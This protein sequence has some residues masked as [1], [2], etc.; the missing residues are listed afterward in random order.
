MKKRRGADSHAKV[1][2]TFHSEKQ[3][4]RIFNGFDFDRSGSVSLTEFHHAVEFCR[5]NRSFKRLGERLD[6]LEQTFV[7]MDTDGDATVDFHEFC[8]GMTGKAKGPF[9]GMSDSDINRLIEMFLI[10]AERARRQT[11][12]Q[13]IDSNAVDESKSDCETLKFFGSLFTKKDGRKNKPTEL[14]LKSDFKSMMDD[15]PDPEIEAIKLQITEEKR[16]DMIRLQIVL[17]MNNILLL[18]DVMY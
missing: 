6:F 13:A 7:A 2:M 1:A 16:Y 17:K 5:N 8:I 4:R 18:Y 15:T 10:Y 12:I 9:D 14:R 11:V 3:L